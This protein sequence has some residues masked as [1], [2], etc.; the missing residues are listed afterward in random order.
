MLARKIAWSL[1]Q[2]NPVDYENLIWCYM[3][4]YV[5]LVSFWMT[6]FMDKFTNIV[7]DDG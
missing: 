1:H 7:M 4:F 6:L 2:P 3:V 5:N